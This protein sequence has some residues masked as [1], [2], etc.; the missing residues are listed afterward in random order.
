MTHSR[1]WIDENFVEPEL[2]YYYCQD[3]GLNLSEFIENG[4][5]ISYIAFMSTDWI[6][7]KKE[8]IIGSTSTIENLS[9][10][11]ESY[12]AGGEYSVDEIS[13]GD[14]SVVLIE[15]RNSPVE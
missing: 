15:K 9:S 11:M 5:D 14:Y 6:N 8:L 12:R 2:I 3:V 4:C 7:M 1:I 10:V 13:S